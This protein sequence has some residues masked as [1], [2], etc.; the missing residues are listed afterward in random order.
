MSF[1]LFIYII[2]EMYTSTLHKAQS[3]IKFLAHLVCCLDQTGEMIQT[4]LNDQA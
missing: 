1:P 2:A 3:K 4:V